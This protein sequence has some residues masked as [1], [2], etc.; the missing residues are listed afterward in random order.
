LQGCGGV[1]A[2]YECQRAWHERAPRPLKAEPGRRGPGAVKGVQEVLKV[3]CGAK[4]DV[5]SYTDV[6]VVF[7]REVKHDHTTDTMPKFMADWVHDACV[8]SFLEGRESVEDMVRVVRNAV[9]DRLATDP[10]LSEEQRA[11]TEDEWLS[12][13]DARRGGTE[14]MVREYGVDEKYVRGV[15]AALRKDM[16]TFSKDPEADLRIWVTTHEEDVF[17]Y[18]SGADVRAHRSFTP[19]AGAYTT[20]CF[21]HHPTPKR[22]RIARSR[23]ASRR[24]GA[25]T[26]RT[27]SLTTLR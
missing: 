6:A 24:S 25:A 14:I 9:L 21:L 16:D 5:I 2:Y 22:S 19:P 3:G 27:S 4:F 7:L 17:L 26:T 1:K 23:W 10:E 20:G 13:W 8:A 11:R 18:R 15:F 12:A